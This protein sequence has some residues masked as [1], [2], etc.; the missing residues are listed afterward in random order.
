MM[1]A[2]SILPAQDAELLLIT[3]W[4]IVMVLDNRA[5]AGWVIYG[6]VATEISGVGIG[7]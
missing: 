6:V 7:S 5:S 4:V 1:S 2:R 3:V